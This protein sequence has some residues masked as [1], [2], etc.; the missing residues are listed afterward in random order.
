MKCKQE[1]DAKKQK[2]R[3]VV[4]DGW[5]EEKMIIENQR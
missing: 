3:I 2:E 5:R 4:M 1:G